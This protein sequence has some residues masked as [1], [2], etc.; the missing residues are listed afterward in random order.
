M[1]H[2]FMFVNDS[3]DLP[4]SSRTQSFRKSSVPKFSIS[5]Q[6]C[7]NYVF[8][9]C[10]NANLFLYMYGLIK[11]SY[12]ILSYLITIKDSEQQLRSVNPE[13]TKYVII[14][15]SDKFPTARAFQKILCKPANKQRLQAFLQ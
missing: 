13:G 12:L 1:Q 2:S 4:I 8:M 14:S 9:L 10:L 7:V 6:Q 11:V 15:A 3:Y 5:V